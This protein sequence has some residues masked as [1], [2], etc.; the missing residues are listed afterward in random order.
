LTFSQGSRSFCALVDGN[1]MQELQPVIRVGDRVR[2]R[3]QRWRVVAARAFD[4]CRLVTLTGLGPFN[5]GL[6]QSV[7]VP[8]D[9]IEPL[10][11]ST[12]I[13][14]VRPQQWRRRCR[15]LIASD[16]SAGQ[17]RALHHAAIDVLPH[18]LEPAL[19]V[20]RG[21]GSRVLLADEVGL[22]KTIQAGLIVAELR[23]RGAADRCLVLA[24]SGLRDQWLSELSDRFAL[25]FI[26]IDA[27]TARVRAAQLPA[28]LNPWTTTPAVITSIDYVK[29]AEVLPAA[30]ASRWDIVVIDE[31]HGA[32]PGSDRH[33]AVAALCR[34]APHVI[35]LTATPHNGEREA[36][37]ALCGLGSHGEPLLVFR[38]DRRAVTL[39]A[40]RR[41]HCV[42]IASTAA[43]RRMHA[44]LARFAQAV[45]AEHGD[46]NRD[47]WLALTT[48]HKRA[49]SSARSLQE[50][51]QR[52]LTGLS[53]AGGDLP[54]QLTLPLDDDRG[55]LDAS[56][57]APPW[58]APAL[59]DAGQEQRL[60]VRIAEAAAL[61][62]KD[63]SKL[64]RLTRL[65]ERLRRMGESAIVF[66]EYRD[67]LEHIRRTLG[68]SCT[69]LHGGMGREE[70]RTALD[71]FRSGRHT[72]LLATDAG[73]EGLSL[74]D[75]CRIVI[76]LELPWNPM[77]L[78]QRVGRVDRIGQRC[79]VHAFN[80]IA[81]DTGEL[82]IFDRLKARI[83]RARNDIGSSD[84][85]E[86]SA[87][88]EAAAVQIVLGAGEPARSDIER[89]PSSS[90]TFV[91]LTD[92]AKDERVKALYVRALVRQ[93]RSSLEVDAVPW[94]TCARRPVTRMRLD[95]N[96][97]LILQTVLEDGTGR[98]IAVRATPIVID[99]ARRLSRRHVGDARVMLRQLIVEP[100]LLTAA[101]SLQQSAPVAAH[102]R[103]WRVRL[104][105]ERAIA[106]SLTESARVSAFQPG[107][108]DARALRERDIR[109]DEISA[110]I[111]EAKRHVQSAELS[112][113]IAEELTHA[114][115]VLVP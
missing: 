54:D 88:G 70:R 41:V 62:A 37:E 84:P 51:V 64:R 61:A 114:A 1:P 77:R 30:L 108:F 48:L 102:E 115:L 19:A 9:R 96:T 59:A 35:L 18:Q 10:A 107:L 71:D 34:R 45:R 43:E 8:F 17:L 42:P 69:T 32:A 46:R 99:T 95:G 14:F 72:L 47:T 89:D 39:G 31:A 82:R 105:R 6:E 29:R 87:A 83:E 60:L 75:R 110:A 55:E 24:P 15:A 20:V 103:F 22:G 4:S 81:R 49:L 56:D 25:P 78:E 7:L 90:R 91:T 36:F 101:G 16:T 26:V 44:L 67:T 13:R 109:A 2:V 97:L 65:L 28:G 80:L 33:H 94:L 112:R 27:H 85:L 38:R 23:A 50:S 74:H 93:S 53:A 11:P 100:A 68:I 52:R 92:D 12:R 63:E 58:T 86:S 21:L 76:N 79:C 106:T 66:T 57:Q 73:G 98:T 113:Q 5:I 40:G 111:E 104:D 3:R